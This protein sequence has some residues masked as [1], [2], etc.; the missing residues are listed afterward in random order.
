MPSEVAYNQSLRGADY[1]GFGVIQAT[2]MNNLNSFPEQIQD[3]RGGNPCEKNALQYQPHEKVNRN[4]KNHYQNYLEESAMM[5]NYDERQQV[6]LDRGLNMVETAENQNLDFDGDGEMDMNLMDT[7]FPTISESTKEDLQVMMD[8]L[9]QEDDKN[10][11]PAESQIQEKS[12]KVNEA[13]NV[14]IQPHMKVEDPR[15]GE[16][17]GE[18]VEVKKYEKPQ[19]QLL[20]PT[21]VPTNK[22]ITTADGVVMGAGALALA[23]MI[24]GRATS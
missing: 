17:A 1:Y 6:D 16:L 2:P 8:N 15:K 14:I 9:P 10:D 12:V 13:E 19:N 22:A 3:N 18:Q 7:K 4:V 24:M 21:S 23:M 11:P 5:M 20:A